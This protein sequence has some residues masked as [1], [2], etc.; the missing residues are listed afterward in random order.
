MY[1][2][3][4]DV[5]EFGVLGLIKHLEQVNIEGNPFEE[6][7][8]QI[9]NFMLG[10]LRMANKKGSPMLFQRIHESNLF[11]TPNYVTTSIPHQL[12]TYQHSLQH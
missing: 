7:E 6:D 5:K 4:Q 8:Q 11:C 9:K 12:S 3:I 1:N 10:A 2:R